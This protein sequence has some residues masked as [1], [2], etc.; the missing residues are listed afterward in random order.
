[1]SAS[2]FAGNILA[3]CA[4]IATIQILQEENILD[5]CKRKGH[6]FLK[7]LQGYRERYPKVLKASN[8]LGLLIGIETVKPKAAIALVKD[9]IAQSVLTAPAF[10]N[11]AV[12]MI[13]PP[14]VISL[15]QTQTVLTAIGKACERLNQLD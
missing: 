13:E 9:M 15:E 11:P 7:T 12:L 5:D 4:A 14:L 2:S 8:G 10:G 6:I 3:S 1:M